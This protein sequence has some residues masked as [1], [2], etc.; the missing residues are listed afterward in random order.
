MIFIK[1]LSQLIK[2]HLE[3]SNKAKNRV[4]SI[5]TYS[6]IDIESQMTA[7]LRMTTSI[8]GEEQSSRRNK[9]EFHLKNVNNEEVKKYI[10][11]VKKFF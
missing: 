8:V 3:K 4:A 7:L 5:S 11:M 9:K 2:K 1:N 6:Y 10:D